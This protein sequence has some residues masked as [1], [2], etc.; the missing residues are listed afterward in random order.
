[1]IRSHRT[2]PRLCRV[3]KETVKT[4][5]ASQGEP[6]IIEIAESAAARVRTDCPVES[7]ALGL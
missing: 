3:S 4:R 5:P 1:M 7:A 6:N 2:L